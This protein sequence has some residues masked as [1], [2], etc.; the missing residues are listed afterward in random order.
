MSVLKCSDGD[1][2]VCCL[3]TKLSLSLQS[4]QNRILGALQS[5]QKLALGVADMLH[6]FQAILLLHVPL[7]LHKFL[8]LKN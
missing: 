6:D 8:R 3:D 7:G 1:G 5:P 2:D 4:L